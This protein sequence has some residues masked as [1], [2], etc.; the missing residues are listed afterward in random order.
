MSEIPLS[1]PDA[2]APLRMVQGGLLAAPFK[3]GMR[4]VTRFLAMTNAVEPLHKH[5]VPAQHWY[6]FILGVDPPHQRKGLGSALLQPVLHRADASNLPCYLETDKEEDILFYQRH[7]FAVAKEVALPKGGPK[8][9][10]ML[11]APQA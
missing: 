9:W 2:R 7:N 1:A 8:M 3:V 5:D 4:A 11:R 10:T 6:L